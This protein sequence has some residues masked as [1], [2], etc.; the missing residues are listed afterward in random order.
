MGRVVHTKNGRLL[1]LILQQR[2]W[3]LIVSLMDTINV[4]SHPFSVW[5]IILPH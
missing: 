3:L 4:T 2:E 5:F 1:Y